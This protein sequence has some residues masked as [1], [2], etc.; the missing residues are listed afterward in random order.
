MGSHKTKAVLLF[1]LAMSFGVL[2]FGGYLMNKEKPPI[3]RAAVT[4]GGET[5][6]AEQDVVEG[7]NYFFSRGGQHMGS[8]WGHG[9][10]LAPD[11]SA[12]YLHRMGLFVAARHMGRSP[13]EAAAFTQA[14][15]TKL[16]AP[17]RARITALVTEELKTNRYDSSSG[18]LTL[19][20]FQ[21]EA[22]AHLVRYYTDLFKNGNERMGLQSD[23]VENDEDG[24]KVASFFS[25]LAWAAG[26]NRPDE[27]YTYTSNWPYDPLVGNQPLPSALIWSIV[28]VILLILGIA[29]AI[30]LYQRYIREEDYQAQLV[31]ELPEPNP[32]ASQKATLAY[33]LVAIALFVIQVGLGSVTG[34]FT[35]EGTSFFGI[36][37]GDI[38]PYAAARTWHVQLAVFFIATCFLAAGLF[39]G[40][41]VGREPKHQSMLVWILFVA[42]V[43]VVLGSLGGTYASIAGAFGGDGFLLGHQGY[44]YIELGRVWQ[45]LLIVGM[46]IW[47]VLVVRAIKPALTSEKDAGGMIHLLL[48]SAVTIPAFYMFGLLYGEGSHLTNAEY[49]RWWVVHLWVEGF[50]EVFATVFMAFLLARIGVIGAKFALRTVYFSVFLYLG[51]G[52]IGTFHHLYWTGAPSPI[53]ALGAVFSALEIVPLT[54]IGFEVVHNLR[55]AKAGAAANP[56]RWPI[57]FFVSVAFWNLV[58]AGIFG[59]LINPPI[60]LY[61]IQGIN[62]TPLHA[63]TA[64]FGVYGL[65]AIS[66]MLF[67]MRHTIAKAAWSDRL[68]KWSFWG[69]N[70][71]LASMTIVS[72]AP[73][74]FYQFYYAVRD[75]LWYA[76]S[77]E[78]TSGEVMRNLA[79]ARIGPDLVFGVGALLLFVFVGRAI[80]MTVK[81]TAS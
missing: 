7:Q 58:G 70:G 52:V 10:Y 79:W 30:F 61:Y 66:L 48:Y 78:I 80:Y 33:F 59:F 63:H 39:I 57:Y 50:F 81:K 44:E 69:L 67:S 73:S 20:A 8:I 46:L 51:S 74:G 2:L 24:R 42:V 19:T 45:I 29:G 53:I 18:N 60:V 37:I 34:H 77:P 5:V 1:M 68:L 25:W 64:L 12:D 47:L 14:D 31:S 38:L 4:T 35:V 23:I 65:L 56:Y 76:R 36:P 28:S 41:F 71:G 75:G 55:A 26:T 32:S 17:T 22:H 16:N 21:A 43:I 54:L 9:A 3:P 6:F 11:W 15:L 40:P 62:T 13:D 72:L 27:G 49:W